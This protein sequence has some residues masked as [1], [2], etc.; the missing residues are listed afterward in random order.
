VKIVVNLTRANRCVRCKAPAPGRLRA[1][2]QIT[3]VPWIAF[4]FRVCPACADAMIE[5][6]ERNPKL[7][8]IK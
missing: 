7:R 3:P 1:A 5:R 6:A 4:K 2:M 8:R